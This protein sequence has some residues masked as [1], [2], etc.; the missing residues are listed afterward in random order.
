MSIAAGPLG[1]NVEGTGSLSSKGKVS[2]MYSYSRTKGL[3]GGASLEG[4]LIVERSDAN[5]KAYRE[6][7]ARL[8]CSVREELCLTNKTPSTFRSERHSKAAPLRRSRSP[9]FRHYPD[10]HHFSPLWFQHRV[11]AGRRRRRRRL[12]T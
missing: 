5:A 6:R 11:A 7:P 12:S 9:R 10:R 2:A 3:F 1:R 4:S 8:T